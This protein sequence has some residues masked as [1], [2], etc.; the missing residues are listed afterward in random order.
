MNICGQC[1]QNFSTE[2]EYL[3]HTCV[4]T[5]HTPQD[6]EHFGPEF[7]AI[8]AEAQARGAERAAQEVP[9]SLGVPVSTPDL[10]IAG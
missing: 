1:D 10:P 9:D 5:G 6:V 7:A 8:S 3:Q 4:K 2:Q